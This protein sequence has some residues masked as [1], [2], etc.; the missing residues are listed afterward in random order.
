MEKL[1]IKIKDKIYL[2]EIAYTDEERK[3]GLQDRKFLAPDEGMIFVFDRQGV[4]KF[5]MKDTLIPL[6]QI[7]I[8]SAEI[9]NKVEQRT[10]EDE[11]L[12]SFPN[13]KYLLELNV[14]SGVLPGDEIEF[15]EEDLSDYTMKVLGSDGST[16]ML[17]KGGERIFS[18][19][20]TLKFI[21]L[22]KLAKELQENNDLENLPKIYKKLGKAILK[23]LYAQNHR[24]KQYVEV[25]K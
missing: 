1:K 22:A 6:D 7:A 16:Q 15:D 25:P 21:R 5:W 12:I 8:N 10:P 23:E 3:K 4:Q 11:T 13:C 14:N 17:L 19:K 18:R 24:E 9:V 20:S 2:C